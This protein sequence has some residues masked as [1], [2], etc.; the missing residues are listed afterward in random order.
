MFRNKQH[1]FLLGLLAG[2]LGLTLAVGPLVAQADPKEDFAATERQL[3]AKAAEVRTLADEVQLLDETID[4]KTRYIADVSVRV[5]KARQELAL[6]NADLTSMQQQRQLAQQ[7]LS[8]FVRADYMDKVPSD[9]ELLV[10]DESLAD[11]LARLTYN[12]SFQRLADRV[13]KKLSKVEKQIGQRQAEAQTRYAALDELESG[14]EREA[15]EL[16][17]I[18]AVKQQFFNQTQ[19]QEDIFRQQYEQ[20]RAALE[21]TGAFARSARDRIGSRVWDDSGFYFNQLDARWIDERL[22]FSSSSTLGDYGCGVADIAMV[23]KYYGIDTNPPKVNNSLKSVRAFV[24]DLLDWR[25]VAAASGGKLQLANNPYPVGRGNVDW[26]FIDAQL[27]AGNPVIVYIDRQ[28]ISHYV[29][30][31]EKRGASYIM[32]DPIEG[33]YL[34]FSDYYRTDAVYQYITFRRS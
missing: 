3:A 17:A 28:S 11:G 22:G 34:K 18:R 12:G 26:R 30:L 20:A 31:L 33:P 24:G 10:G 5:A 16:S 15:A 14:A 2:L 23:F 6:I 32:H 25:N 13:V 4:A 19:G 29:V 7:Q 1:K 27:A 9:Y 8:R 21:A